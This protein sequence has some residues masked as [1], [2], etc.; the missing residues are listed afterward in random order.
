[1]SLR[2]VAC[3]F[4]KI[5][6]TP[7]ANPQPSPFEVMTQEVAAPGSA[8]DAPESGTQVVADAGTAQETPAAT[9]IAE[10]S[11]SEVVF[12]GSGVAQRP[13]D[14]DAEMRDGA[15]VDS[16]ADALTLV[17]P[18]PPSPGE[19]TCGGSWGFHGADGFVREECPHACVGTCWS[20]KTPL[21][22]SHSSV[23]Q[24]STGRAGLACLS[25]PSTG[26]SGAP[27][28]VF[29]ASTPEPDTLPKGWQTQALALGHGVLALNQL[30]RAVHRLGFSSATGSEATRLQDSTTRSMTVCEQMLKDIQK[31]GLDDD[32]RS[33][34]DNCRQRLASLFLMNQALTIDP[35]SSREFFTDFLAW[36]RRS[37][38]RIVR[39]MRFSI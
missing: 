26:G 21:C 34:L 13:L 17:L 11:D 31:E 35:V 36:L 6:R 16:S 9:T 22:R 25:C 33:R 28:P 3:S 14:G 1:M 2:N 4:E 29:N 7:P 39:C 24:L 32:S 23:I 5:P 18:G 8:Q 38:Q 15:L 19:Q 37:T 20:C 12:I 27:L 30:S 10:H